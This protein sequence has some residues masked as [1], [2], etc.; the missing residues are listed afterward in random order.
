MKC[1]VNNLPDCE[2]SAPDICNSQCLE[3]K[4][5]T[6][7]KE[8]DDGDGGSGQTRDEDIEDDKASDDETTASVCAGSVTVNQSG[9]SEYKLVHEA[10]IAKN[11]Q[12]LHELGLKFGWEDKEGATSESKSTQK[13]NRKG[14]AWWKQATIGLIDAG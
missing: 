12:L 14:K 3:S 13:K 2:T 5:I 8:D 6:P 10:N 9:K 4:A 7:G 11:R 1:K